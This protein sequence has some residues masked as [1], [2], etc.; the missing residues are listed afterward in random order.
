MT[1]LDTHIIDC[2]RCHAIA[3]AVI[4][5][6]RALLPATALI[7]LGSWEDAELYREAMK[8]LPPMPL[9]PDDFDHFNARCCGGEERFAGVRLLRA[10]TA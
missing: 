1:A 10:G 8:T 5:H 9:P 7:P 2:K 4:S 6:A 3:D